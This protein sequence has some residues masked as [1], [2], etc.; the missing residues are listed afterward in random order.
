M[1]PSWLD[2]SKSL[3]SPFFFLVNIS[4]SRTCTGFPAGCNSSRILRIACQTLLWMIT[5]LAW[6][7]VFLAPRTGNTYGCFRRTDVGGECSARTKPEI[8]Q[9][10]IKGHGRKRKCGPSGSASARFSIRGVDV[11]RVF[12]GSGFQ[13]CRHYNTPR[14][15]QACTRSECN[16]GKQNWAWLQCL[17]RRA[18]RSR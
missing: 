1:I 2:A 12:C 9:E 15:A 6:R 4:F 8:T 18:R 16:V 13:Y 14:L 3:G 11:R 10:S 5:C 7:S 17:S